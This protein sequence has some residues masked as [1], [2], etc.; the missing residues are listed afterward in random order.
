MP[1]TF[2]FNLLDFS[3]TDLCWAYIVCRTLSKV[4]KMFKKKKKKTVS[5]NLKLTSFRGDIIELFLRKTGCQCAYSVAKLCLTLRPRRLKP[6]R[7][8]CPWDFLGK[9]TGV[10]CHFLLHGLFS[11]LWVSFFFLSPRPPFFLWLISSLVI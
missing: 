11:V 3:S 7:L 6:A 1:F 4:Q 9:N 5:A 10:G 8:L 2:E